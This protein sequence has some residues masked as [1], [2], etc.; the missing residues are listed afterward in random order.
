MHSQ[1]IE[2]NSFCC[3]G[4]STEQARNVDP[5]C[6]MALD[7]TISE[8]SATH[9]GV[10]YH[11]CS[12]RCLK[13]FNKNREKIAAGEGLELKKNRALPLGILGTASLLILF[14][15]VVVLANDTV[16]IALSEVKR[17]W[18][19]VL[20]LST[21]FGLQLGLFVHIRHL[22]QQ[23]MACA[24]AEVAASGA[25]STGSMI[26]CCSHGLVNLLPV[27][28]ISAAA[29]FLARYQLPFVLLGVFSNLVGVTI[30]VGLAQKNSISFSNPLLCGIAGFN[31]KIV[32][33]LLIVTGI[34]AIGVSVAAS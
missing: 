23:R 11:F 1:Y 25:V 17:L 22:L 18:Y 19:W 29:V 15:T 16:G 34:I 26:A 7:G 9:A 2:Q 32:R 12:T 3:E 33:L 28:G 5:I 31:M 6:G 10:D 30:M 24:T 13:I 20:L 27:F 8:L 21:G 14:L 4:A